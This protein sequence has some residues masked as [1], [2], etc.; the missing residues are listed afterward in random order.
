M[1]PEEMQRENFK[2]FME[3]GPRLSRR[4]NTWA[5]AKCSEHNRILLAGL[6]AFGMGHMWS[7]RQEGISLESEDV[8]DDCS[9]LDDFGASCQVDNPIRVRLLMP[10]YP[11]GA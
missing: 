9:A 8:P 5:A 3:D 6:G 1:T 4:Y 2:V 11:S 10:P 7:D